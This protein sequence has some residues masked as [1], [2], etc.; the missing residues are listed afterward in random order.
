MIKQF[1]KGFL[2]TYTYYYIAGLVMV[3]I[4]LGTFYLEDIPMHLFTNAL[5]FILFLGMIITCWLFYHA[6]E[7]HSRLR[8]M[9]RNI[10]ALNIHKLPKR[11]LTE[12][13]FKEIIMRLEQV[14]HNE[15][16]TL[17]SEQ[18]EMIDYYGM[19]SHQIKVPLAVLD[20]MVQTNEIDV[21][22]MKDELMYVNQYIE[23]IL[24][25]IRMNQLQTDY[26]FKEV[27]IEKMVKRSIKKYARFFIKKNL[28]IT[29]EEI[30]GAVIS[31][32]K[33]LEFVFEQLLFNAIKYTQ[34]GGVTIQFKDNKLSITDTGIGIL[35]EDLPR[36]FESG[37]TGF[38]GRLDKKASGLGLF[39]SK[40]ILSKF[41]D[42]ITIQSEINVGTTVTIHFHEETKK[43]S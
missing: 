23:M 19:W 24:Q 36:I 5:I 37:F 32:E 43:F 15:L 34:V 10:E 22:T 29:I 11:T 39:M 1:I 2:E 16:T 41:G 25:Y 38:N 3:G 4:F 14:H 40:Q 20:L 33:W 26:L 31:D 7:K 42:E 30:N 6:Y 28:S 17:K 27:A 8:T 35:P 13:D 12:K 18:Q 21:E 9:L